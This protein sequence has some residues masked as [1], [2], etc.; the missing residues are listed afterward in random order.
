MSIPFIDLKSQYV[1]IKDEIAEAIN[2]VLDHGQY[3]LGPAVKAFEDDVINFTNAYD[4]VSAASGTDALV[5]PLMAKG[6]GPGDAVFLPAF[7]YTAT[8]EV[9]ALVGATPVFVDVD[10]DTFNMD[11]ASLEAEIARVSAEG[12]LTPRIVMPVDLFGLPADYDTLLP[13]ARAHGL[14]VIA[15]AAQSFG[16]AH[17]GARVG[18][19]APT[20]ATS[21][22]PA[23]PLGCY[24]DGGAIMTIENDLGKV[25]RSIRTHGTGD[26]KYDV[27]RIGLN[28]RL[29]TIQAAVLSVKL[30]IFEDELRT[31]EN[32]S[33]KYDSELSG[34]VETPHRVVGS[35]SAW[36]QYVIKVP[37]SAREN[38]QN[39]LK[40]KG[41][42]TMIYYPKPM[43]FQQAYANWGRGAESMPVSEALCDTV[44]A[45]PMH[46]YLSDADFETICTTIRQFFGRNVV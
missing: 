22:F 9:A 18:S 17:N 26:H 6:V 28:G 12:K 40:A 20:T 25:L 19:L 43:H 11:H 7:T 39:A 27:V 32:L 13:I 5:I 41:C 15:D 23:K 2:G 10:A 42:P 38:L 24:G 45:L 8:A 4:C 35:E 33:R 34:Y 46:A 29:D 21:F 3:V 14:E 16:G 31:K 44:L 37:K 36:A 1:R 30:K